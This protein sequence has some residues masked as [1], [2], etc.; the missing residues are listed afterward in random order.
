MLKK[1]KLKDRV[2]PKTGVHIKIEE[3]WFGELVPVV[4]QEDVPT[5]LDTDEWVTDLEL[6]DFLSGLADERFRF[7]D[8]DQWS[9]KEAFHNLTHFWAT[10]PEIFFSSL[11]Q[12]IDCAAIRARMDT[13]HI[14]MFRIKAN[15]VYRLGRA[16]GS[17]SVQSLGV[18]SVLLGM[19][20][21]GF[22]S[23]SALNLAVAL[24]PVVVMLNSHYI[25]LKDPDEKLVFEAVAA[26]MNDAKVVDFDALQKKDYDKAYR[27]PGPASKEIR[28]YIRK[29]SPDEA[30]SD[31]E[32]GKTLVRLEEKGILKENKRHWRIAI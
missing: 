5:L 10:M 4:S 13:L 9:S 17:S 20:L 12:D 6:R 30:I 22:T 26:L 3:G 21:L 32:I 7:V 16:L 2:D 23:I 29:F 24:A 1:A 14:N 8:L 25:T 19:Q 31:R 15:T 11:P 18:L 27:T 28:E